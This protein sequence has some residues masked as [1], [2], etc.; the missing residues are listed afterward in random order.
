MEVLY[1]TALLKQRRVNYCLRPKGQQD[2]GHLIGPVEID[3]LRTIDC[4]YDL[5]PV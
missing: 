5:A 1:Q 2:Q 3:E 4:G